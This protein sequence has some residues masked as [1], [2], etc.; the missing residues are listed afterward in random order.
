MIDTSYEAF[1]HIF[2]GEPKQSSLV[3]GDYNLWNVIVDSETLAVRGIIDP[4]EAG[5][6]DREIDLFQLQNANGDRFGLL[7][8]YRSKVTLSDNFLVKN[9]FYRFGKT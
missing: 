1:D 3:H 2:A 9:A 8:N 7:D 4:F 5:W 6:A